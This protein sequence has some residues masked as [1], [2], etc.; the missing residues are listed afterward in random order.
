M[1]NI[2]YILRLCEFDH[3]VI[4]YYRLTILLLRVSEREER[5]A[6]QAEYTR[7]FS[8]MKMLIF[9]HLTMGLK[10]LRFPK[11]VLGA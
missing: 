11:C 10:A 8:T 2:L 1:L 3:F 7:T 5:H 4:E 9:L 6:S